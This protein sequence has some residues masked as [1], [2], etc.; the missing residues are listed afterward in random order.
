MANK[1]YQCEKYLPRFSWVALKRWWRFQYLPVAINLLELTLPD[2]DQTCA[3][4]TFSA[5]STLYCCLAYFNASMHCPTTSNCAAQPERT[6]DSLSLRNYVIAQ[7]ESFGYVASNSLKLRETV[8][9]QCRHTLETGKIHVVRYIWHYFYCTEER[10]KT[11]SWS[12]LASNRKTEPVTARCIYSFS[13]L[14]VARLASCP[15]G[16]RFQEALYTP[17]ACFARRARYT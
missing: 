8:Q 7:N 6:F 9:N 4:S 17:N 16:G 5:D 13:T 3:T 14:Y 2:V 15:S 1:L 11:H 12:R 10:E